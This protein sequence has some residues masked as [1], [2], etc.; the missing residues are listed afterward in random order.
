[1]GMYQSFRELHFTRKR[2]ISYQ[3]YNRCPVVF[4]N[5]HPECLNSVLHLD[6]RIISVILRY[7]LLFEDALLR[8]VRKRF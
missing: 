4:S 2:R 7:S 6:K 3:Q 8:K 5:D 1:M